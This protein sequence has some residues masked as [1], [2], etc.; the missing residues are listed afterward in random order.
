MIHIYIFIPLTPLVPSG[1]QKSASDFLGVQLQLVLRHLMCRLWTKHE[2][3][4]GAALSQPSSIK[5]HYNAED[6]LA[7]YTLYLLPLGGDESLW[8]MV[9]KEPTGFLSLCEWSLHMLLIVIVNTVLLMGGRQQKDWM[10]GVQI[11]LGKVP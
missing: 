11:I 5:C 8:W 4:P 1:S 6:E 7:H 10:N 9:M 2:Y 3:R